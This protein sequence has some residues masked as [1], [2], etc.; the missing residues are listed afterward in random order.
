MYKTMIKF[1][2]NMTTYKKNIKII[3]RVTF[4]FILI[5]VA[6][7]LSSLELSDFV[8]QTAERHIDIQKGRI[9]YKTAEAKLDSYSVWSNP[10]FSMEWTERNG[11]GVQS[12]V[13]GYTVSQ[14]LP[15][16][17]EKSKQKKILKSQ[18][19][20]AKAQDLLL[21]YRAKK[22]ITLNLFQLAILN[23]QRN[24]YKKREQWLAL[25]KQSI[26]SA[27]VSSKSMALEKEMVSD[28][29]RQA[30]D[31]VAQ[32]DYKI[33]EAT[34]QLSLFGVDKNRLSTLMIEWFTPADLIEIKNVLNSV[35]RFSIK[36]AVKNNLKIDKKMVNSDRSSSEVLSDYSPDSLLNVTF[37]QQLI[38]AQLAAAQNQLENYKIRPEFEIYFSK[39]RQYL[40][41]GEENA[42]IGISVEI[43]LEQALQSEKK[44]KQFEIDQIMI[45]RDFESLKQ[46][47]LLENF[48]AEIETLISSLKR[49][50]QSQINQIYKSIDTH[51]KSFQT[52]WVSLTQFLE[53]DRQ[54][55][56]MMIQ[57]L[58]V[59]TN[60]IE[61]ILNKCEQADC[62]QVKIIKG[63]I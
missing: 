39:D 22:M 49:Y 11:E 61:F 42:T 17:T 46:K 25:I 19:S 12:N 44:I 54:K 40:N 35:N 28:A 23:E 60:T 56:E 59:Q 21:S 33:I 8:L 14:K 38:S 62:N 1:R 57:I 31:Q 34:N 5:F 29:L 26:Y 27:Q 9:E 3:S 50:P 48:E 43:P 10:R 32:L 6:P 15:F 53:L 13:E 45:Q 47:T 55:S 18:V 20:I 36:N 4:F 2:I 24:F 41:R 16:W 58:D 7:P 30:E 51:K 63:Q 52:G 37:E